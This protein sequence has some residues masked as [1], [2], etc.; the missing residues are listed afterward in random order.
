MED[1]QRW[2][3]CSG[4]KEQ[5]LKG[6]SGERQFL[7]RNSAYLYPRSKNVIQKASWQQTRN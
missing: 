1:T 7:S 6:Y 3:V 2:R 4:G 5:Y